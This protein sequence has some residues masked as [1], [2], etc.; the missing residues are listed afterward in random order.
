MDVR[1]FR[2]VVP[3]PPPNASE[4][5][6]V[7]WRVMSNALQLRTL[8]LERLSPSV[9]LA[10]FDG[11]PKCVWCEEPHQAMPFTFRPRFIRLQSTLT[12]ARRTP[13]GEDETPAS[14][15]A[16]PVRAANTR[17]I[18]VQELRNRLHRLNDPALAP[19]TGSAALALECMSHP[20]R[21][22]FQ[23]GAG[24]TTG[25]FAPTNPVAARVADAELVRAVQGLTE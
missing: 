19:Q 4:A 1:A 16:V 9:L 22:R 2:E 14:S 12:I 5:D 3:A 24:A 10:L 17:V 7:E 25:G 8:R 20:W 11:V 6:L 15:L 21:Q 18:A 23:E 13:L